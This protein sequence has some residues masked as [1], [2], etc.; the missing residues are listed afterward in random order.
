M[1]VTVVTG[2]CNSMESY[3]DTGLF[4]KLDKATT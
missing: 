1:R 2:K 3:V 4:F